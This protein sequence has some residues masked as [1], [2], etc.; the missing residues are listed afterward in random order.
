[1]KHFFCVLLGAIILA[2]SGH[3]PAHSSDR[4][5]VRADGFELTEKDVSRVVGHFAE[6]NIFVQR[7]VELQGVLRL[8]LF[9]EEALSLGLDGD[10]QELDPTDVDQIM[11]LRNKYLRHLMEGYPVSAAVVESYYYSHPDRFEFEGISL[12]RETREEISRIVRRANLQKLQGK[13]Y[14][15]LMEKYN[16]VFCDAAGGCE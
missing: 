14:E 1:M 3:V 11:N 8:R 7:D 13:A 10:V 9:A 16:I 15:K 6:M 4:P 2:I 12:D 5:L